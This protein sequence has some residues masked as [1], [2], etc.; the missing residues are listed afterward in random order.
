MHILID[1]TFI[2]SFSTLFQTLSCFVAFT[3]R[4]KLRIIILNH[5]AQPHPNPQPHQQ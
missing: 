2:S 1:G 5:K 3:K 4:L